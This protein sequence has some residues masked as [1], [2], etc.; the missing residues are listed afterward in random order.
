MLKSKST[1]L[2]LLS[3]ALLALAGCTEHTFGGDRSEVSP[4]ADQTVVQAIR[5][6]DDNTEGPSYQITVTV[7]E[8]WAAQFEV[9]NRGNAI[10]FRYLRGPE[11]TRVAAPFLFIDALSNEQYWEQI[12]SY[13]GQFTNISNTADT[14]FVYHHP[15]DEFYLRISEDDFE[16]LVDAVPEVIRSVEIVRQDRIPALAAGGR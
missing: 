11:E 15:I 8:A 9:E 3:V 6:L 5:Y 14:Y 16:A 12:G 2:I 4:I 7:P 10:V 1:C 13:P